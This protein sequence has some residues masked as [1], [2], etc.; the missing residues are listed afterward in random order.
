MRVGTEAQPA[1]AGACG[2]LASSIEG[3][4]FGKAGIDEMR[5]GKYLSD[6]VHTGSLLAADSAPTLVASNH[7]LTMPR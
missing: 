1:W 7:A 4:G 2:Q 3:V 5:R 6:F